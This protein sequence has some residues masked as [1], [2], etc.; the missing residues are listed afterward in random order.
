MSIGPGLIATHEGGPGSTSQG[1]Q[2]RV[3]YR[4]LRQ[5]PPPLGEVV[6]RRGMPNAE[7]HAD[8]S[9]YSKS[10]LWC[11]VNDGPEAFHARYVERSVH[12]EPSAS[13]SH[14]TLLHGWFEHGDAFWQAAITPPA[15]TLTG[16]GA[17]GKA[18]KEWHAQN[19]PDATLVSPS[20]MAQLR[21]EVAALE[22]D[23]AVADILKNRVEAEVS[24]WFD[25]DDFPCRCRPDLIAE[26]NGE[27]RVIDLKTT[28]ETNLLKNWWRSVTSFGYHAQ[29]YLY[30]RGAEAMGLRPLP[31]IFVVVSTT[32]PHEVLVCTL[33][34]ALTSLG[35]KRIHE[36]IAELRLRLSTDCWVRDH[37][38]EVLELPVPEF[39]YGG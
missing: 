28:R 24:V 29:D 6:V 25:V 20:E 9:A 15:S 11:L 5:P 37:A 3:L 17:I 12:A 4:P 10:P 22:A 19:C 13:M 2:V 26:V 33:P 34:P 31:L 18:A 27:Q 1:S 30:Q 14:G 16:G 8:T 39:V 38:G 23:P 32:P 21:A 36:A 7:Y 35:G